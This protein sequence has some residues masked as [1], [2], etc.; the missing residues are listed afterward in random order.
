MEIHLI[1][2]V[3]KVAAPSSSRLLL[4][5]AVKDTLSEHFAQLRNTARAQGAANEVLT[6]APSDLALEEI[7]TAW[8]RQYVKECV[9]A[10]NSPATINAKLSFVSRVF[11][12]NKA[13][14]T[15]HGG[16]PYKP[17]MPWAP[18]R[19]AVKW[20]LTPALAPKVTL[21]LRQN[22]MADYADYV[23]WT[24]NSGLRVEETLRVQRDHFN[25]DAKT[26]TVPG[27][28]SGL[29]QRVIPLYSAAFDLADRRLQT[30]LD[31]HDYLFDFAP[32]DAA[33]EKR[34]MGLSHTDREVERLQR[35]Y[36]CVRRAWARVKDVFGLQRDKTATLKALRRSFAKVATDNG[37]PTAVLQ[38]YL[39]HEDIETTM[40]YLKVVGGYNLDVIR[41]WVS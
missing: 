37:M 5:D 39:G 18:K 20:W 40:E 16:R 28:K 27:T 10:K 1:E 24:T 2:E 14:L 12:H 15:Q 11:E 35:N 7:D 36:N 22:H 32:A 33:F 17:E 31:P 34:C 29:A 13:K 4:R 23:E 38:Q 30:K 41:R 21:W 19:N 3:E 25:F 8:L 9:T 6:R 26:L